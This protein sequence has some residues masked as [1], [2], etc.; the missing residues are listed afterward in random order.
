M[1]VCVRTEQ[2]DKEGG[3]EE[4]EAEGGDRREG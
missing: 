4:G 2:R 1:K 3:V